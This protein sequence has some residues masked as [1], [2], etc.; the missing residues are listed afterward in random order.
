LSRVQTPAIRERMISGLMNVDREFAG[1]I[2]DGLGMKTLPAPMPT[3]LDGE[4][5]SEVVASPSLSLMARPGVLGIKGRRV[6]ILVSDGTDGAV[7]EAVTAR[8]VSGGAVPRLVGATLGVVTTTEGDKEVDTTVEATP[9]VL[10]DAVVLPDGKSSLRT[11]GADGRVIEFIKDQ[12]RHCK[13]LLVFGDATSL[14]LKI[15]IP[16]VLFSRGTDP[17]LIVSADGDTDSAIEAF[18]TAV[19]KHRHFAR[20]TDPPLV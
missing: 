12:Y 4:V 16:A 8:L 3:A 2:A 1:A 18:M 15:G 7:V 20:E 6:A 5:V 14:L 13:S 11:L 9:S 10:F 19:A 17:G